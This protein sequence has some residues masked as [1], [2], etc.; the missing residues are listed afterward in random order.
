[1]SIMRGCSV[2]IGV[3]LQILVESAWWVK[4][5][6]KRVEMQV[7]AGVRNELGSWGTI[8]GSVSKAGKAAPGAE[9][10][11]HLMVHASESTNTWRSLDAQLEDH[12]IHCYTEWK[13]FESCYRW[14]QQGRGH[15]QP[16]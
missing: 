1:M 10:M 4:G 15:H 6:D 3:A 9:L 12:E 5:G 2:S 11:A 16:F 14:P 8:K 13:I 7:L